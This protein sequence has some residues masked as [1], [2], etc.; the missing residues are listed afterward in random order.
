MPPAKGARHLKWQRAFE[1]ALDSD[2][3]GQVPLHVL[4]EQ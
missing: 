2:Q 4:T 1:D 3:W